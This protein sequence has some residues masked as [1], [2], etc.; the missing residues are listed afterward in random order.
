[1]NSDFKPPP[2]GLS[3]LAAV[4]GVVTAVVAIA[5]LQMVSNHLSKRAT[6]VESPVP[7]SSKT[8]PESSNQAIALA[9]LDSQ[10]VQVPGEPVTAAQIA[11]TKTP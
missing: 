10:S 8:A 6:V 5:G 4:G 2:K 3:I 1:M 9:K 11:A 7:A